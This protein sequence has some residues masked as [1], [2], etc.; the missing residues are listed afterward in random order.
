MSNKYNLLAASRETSL[1][2]PVA[3]LL[4]QFGTAIPDDLQFPL[5]CTQDY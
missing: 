4:L 1:T 2:T 3:Q 5:H